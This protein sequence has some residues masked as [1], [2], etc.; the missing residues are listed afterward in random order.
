LDG[1]LVQTNLFFTMVFENLYGSD[2]VSF[3]ADDNV[4]TFGSAADNYPV[5]IDFDAVVEFAPGVPTPSR[6]EA[7]TAMQS[8]DLNAYI[9]QYVWESEP[10]MQSLFYDTQRVRYDAQVVSMG[11]R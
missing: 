10:V 9:Q 1:L 3:S 6:D 5:R 8:S 11:T 4:V 2:F 7:F